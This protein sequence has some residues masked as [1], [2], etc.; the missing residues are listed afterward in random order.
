MCSKAREDPSLKSYCSSRRNGVDQPTIK[1]RRIHT[2]PGKA[3]LSAEDKV[4][5]EHIWKATKVATG[6]VCA[7]SNRALKMKHV[8]NS[9]CQGVFGAKE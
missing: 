8:P 6:E 9:N 1:C 2:H 5:T 4:I 3:A 7:C